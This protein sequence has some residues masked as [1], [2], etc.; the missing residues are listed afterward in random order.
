MSVLVPTRFKELRK[1]YSGRKFS[2]L[3]VGAG[4]HSAT[5]T[6]QWFPLCDYYG[7]DK[8]KSYNNDASD[9]EAMTEF[10]ELDLTVLDFTLIPEN[11]FDVIIMSHVIEHL[12][13]GDEVLRLLLNKLKSGGFIY[14]EFP[15]KRS[16]RFP[17]KRDTLNFYDDPTHCRIF[18]VEEISSILPENKFQVLKSGVRRDWLRVLLTP[19]KI[20][21]TKITQGYVP[22]SVFWDILGF[23]DFVFARKNRF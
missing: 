14:V 1:I 18:T 9:F 8:E 23:A 20:V 6:K 15:S 2:L 17:S 7:I 21:F 13:N 5:I 3:D 10:Y 22:G 11:F 12:H 4:S 19:V 16:T